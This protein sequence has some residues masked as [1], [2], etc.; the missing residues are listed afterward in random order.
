VNEAEAGSPDL[1][2]SHLWFLGR[3][4]ALAEILQGTQ[5]S[6]EGSRVSMAGTEFDLTGR[7]LI[8][9]VRNPRDGGSVVAAILSDDMESLPSILRKLPHYGRNSYLVFD[10]EKAIEKG[11]W[12]AEVSPLRT[13]FVAR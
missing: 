4:D 8:C 1:S 13:E 2:A 12:E 7:T 5:V 10:G 3:G 6:L 11:V 9:T